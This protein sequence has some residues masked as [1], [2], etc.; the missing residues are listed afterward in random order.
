MEVHGQK[1]RGIPLFLYAAPDD[2]RRSD[3]QVSELG[4]RIRLHRFLIG[5]GAE[6][7]P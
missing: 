7:S 1:E 4:V 5:H 2:D 6:L 3:R